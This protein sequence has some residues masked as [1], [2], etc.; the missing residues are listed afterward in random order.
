MVTLVDAL[1]GLSDHVL[2]VARAAGRRRRVTARPIHRALRAHEIP[3]GWERLATRLLQALQRF[4]SIDHWI[5][6]RRQAGVLRRT[7]RPIGKH[8]LAGPLEHCGTRRFG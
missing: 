5:S 6:D 8:L 4:V 1:R 2:R 3:E 7:L